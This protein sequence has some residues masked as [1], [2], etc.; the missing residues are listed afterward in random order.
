MASISAALLA[1][2][3]GATHSKGDPVSAYSKTEQ[4]V[5]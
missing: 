5:C 3:F 2:G 4:P 1:R